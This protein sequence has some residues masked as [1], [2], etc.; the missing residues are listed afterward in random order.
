MKQEKPSIEAMC[1]KEAYSNQICDLVKTLV[2]SYYELPLTA[3]QSKSRKR[4][5]IKMKQASVYFMRKLL[6]KATLLYIGRQMQYDHA[7]VLHCLK[8]ISN[9]LETDRETRMDIQSLGKNIELQTDL[10]RLDGKINEDYHYINLDICD[11]FKLPDSRGI[12]LSN[13]SDEQVLEFEKFLESFYQIA[14]ER[15]THTNTGLF[16]IEKNKIIDEEKTLLN[17][18][19][20]DGEPNTIEQILDKK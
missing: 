11:S 9:L 14:P 16:I 1:Q 18:I 19:N 10:V 17:I 8:C 7:T 13:F 20:T 12:V 5:V 15:H 6:P 2:S 4:Q 3:Y